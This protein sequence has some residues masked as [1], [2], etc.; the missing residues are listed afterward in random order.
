VAT[1]P[2]IHRVE[3]LRLMVR[4]VCG[5]GAKP[6]FARFTSATDQTDISILRTWLRS[7]AVCALDAVKREEKTADGHRGPVK[8]WKKG[9]DQFPTSV[10]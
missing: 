5:C 2:P 7:D 6:R 9:Q 4:Y 10:T 1:W 8:N 3:R